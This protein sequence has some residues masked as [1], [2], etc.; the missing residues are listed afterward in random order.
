MGIQQQNTDPLVSHPLLLPL[1]PDQQLDLVGGEHVLQA[2]EWT[3]T[4]RGL[5]PQQQ[6]TQ[7]IPSNIYYS[8]WSRSFLCTDSLKPPNSPVQKAA[9]RIRIVHTQGVP[10]APEVTEFT[11]G[12]AGLLPLPPQPKA[13][14]TRTLHCLMA[15][16]PDHL[17]RQLN[18]GRTSTEP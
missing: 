10:K 16:L 3:R 8:S 9:V 4:P 5:I 2:A 15:S 14:L 13:T 6:R 11:V 12:D 1:T 17:P 18:F 7:R